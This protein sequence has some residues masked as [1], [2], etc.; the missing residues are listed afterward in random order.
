MVDQSEQLADENNEF[1]LELERVSPE[2]AGGLAV[3]GSPPPMLSLRDRVT[4]LRALPNDAG[5]AA[6]LQAWHSFAAANPAAVI[7]RVNGRDDG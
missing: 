4:I 3:A 6:F 5:V 2:A 1:F 7:C